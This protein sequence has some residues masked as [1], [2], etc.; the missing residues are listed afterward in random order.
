[1]QTSTINNLSWGWPGGLGGYFGRHEAI[2][3]NPV[4]MSRLKLSPM[5]RVRVSLQDSTSILACGFTNRW[6]TT[7]CNG[8]VPAAAW[9]ANGAQ[10]PMPSLIEGRRL[11]LISGGKNDC[12]SW[13]PPLPL[14]SHT[15]PGRSSATRHSPGVEPHLSFTCKCYTTRIVS[16]FSRW[17]YTMPDMVRTLSQPSAY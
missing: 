15:F 11:R 10:N 6:T 8:T 17:R 2:R 14:S 3:L 5:S 1:M 4:W 16:T 12:D 13:L 9:Q 7:S